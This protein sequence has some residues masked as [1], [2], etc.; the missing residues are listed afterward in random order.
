MGYQ[1]ID[2][3]YKNQAIL[4]FRECY[5]MEKIHG[6]S[7]H[8][9]WNNG[10]IDFF[11]G[12]V[13][14]EDFIKLFDVEKLKERFTA[15]GHE[16]L[17]V[18]GEAYGG[19][20]QGMS[21]TY[22]KDLKFVAFEVLHNDKWLDVPIAEAIC[23]T[24]EIE[25]VSYA[26][27]PAELSALD[28]ERDKP[29]EQSKRN[30]IAGPCI[31]EGVVLRPIHEFTDHRGNRIIAKHKRT[32]FSERKSIPNVDPTQRVLMEQADAI[33]EEWVTDMR[34]RHVLDKLNIEHDF[35]NIPDVIAAMQEDVTREAL[36]EIVDNK[37]VRKAIG[38]ATVKMYKKFITNL[39]TNP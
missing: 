26:R 4:L 7:A 33:A 11:P 39:P 2:N 36:G 23:K 20:C 3:L 16:R 34:M 5:A 37:A 13:K 10:I 35:K 32:E 30:G 28:A 19:K 15:L 1:H 24:L 14:H 25:F 12:G 9:S 29:S 22:G 31:A 21:A 8:I 38:A 18:Y 27:V 6:T 17:T